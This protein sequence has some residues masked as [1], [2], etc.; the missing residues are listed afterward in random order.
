VQDRQ[1]PLDVFVGRA[2]ELARMA[3]V[4]ARVEAGQPW[5]V[6]IEGDPGVGKTALARRCL[7]Q[8]V[9]LKVMA[10]RADQAEAD[11]EF[12]LVDQLLRTAGAVVQPVL[13]AAA[14]GSP[15]SSFAVG[16]RLL[17]VVGD[18]QARGPVAILVDDLQWADRRSVEALTFM[19]RRLSVD[20]VL[21][22]VIFRGPSGR[23]GE[24]AQR[25]LASIEN[26]LRLPLGGLHA[27][28][29][30]ALAAALGA[31]PLGDDVVQRLYRGTG[32]HALYLRTVLGEGSGFDPGAPGRLALPKS[33]AAAIGDQLR[34]LPAETQAIVEMLSV[35][36]LRMALAQLG[37]AA[38][39]D[40]PSAAIE[41]AVAF[42]LV[43]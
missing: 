16:A 33:L 17:E 14:G 1:V 13:A 30:A 18:R 8:A 3:E 35:L 12:G 20:P 28:E 5:L 9:G 21:A 22:V 19:L 42:G 15:A 39:V 40:S 26:R 27:D 36:N 31:G 24:A 43:E 7:A 25:M 2:A 10:A 11:L 37:Q 41:P 6:A 23:L 38:Q 32:G 29:V 4:I 34:V